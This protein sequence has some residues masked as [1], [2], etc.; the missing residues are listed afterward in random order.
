MGRGGALASEGRAHAGGQAP[1][2]RISHGGGRVQRA[3]GGRAERTIRAQRAD[4]G[5][6]HRVGGRASTEG[7]RRG[8]HR[9]RW[10]G[11]TEGWGG[12][13]R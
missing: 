1:P 10:L 11:G 5:R 9:G 12:M 4:A 13:V 8:G 3:A 2:G 6:A 7:Q